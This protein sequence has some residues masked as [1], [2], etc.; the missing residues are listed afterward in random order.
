MKVPVA[1][2]ATAR[3]VVDVEGLAGFFAGA[4]VDNAVGVADLD[5]DGTAT[6][7]TGFGMAGTGVIF[8]FAGTT[9]GL[10]E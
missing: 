10:D 2:R 8:A 9:I 5:S 4:A 3:L 7:A 1:S 6:L